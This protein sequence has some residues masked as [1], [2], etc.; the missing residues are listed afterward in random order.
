V[1]YPA[2]RKEKKKRRRAGFDGGVSEKSLRAG[3]SA[4]RL[5]LCEKESKSTAKK[6]THADELAAGPVTTRSENCPPTAADAPQPASP[7]QGPTNTF[8]P[9]RVGAEF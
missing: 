2:P 7:A 5:L 8:T 6:G 9:A 1:V 3:R 4:H